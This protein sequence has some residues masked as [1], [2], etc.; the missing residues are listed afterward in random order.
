M[1]V[2]PRN[3][4][5]VVMGPFET[6]PAHKAGIRPGDVILEINDKKTDSLNTSEIA[7]LLKGPR[8]SKVKV[9]GI[10]RAIRKPS[11]LISFAT[12]WR[13]PASRRRILRSPA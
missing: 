10:A 5:T 2:G 9:T 8:G 4:K 7:D 3:G 13:F 11:F 1:Q 6:S 12:R